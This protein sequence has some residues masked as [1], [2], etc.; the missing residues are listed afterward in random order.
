MTQVSLPL[1]K[2]AALQQ[3]HALQKEEI[4]ALRCKVEDNTGIMA[5]C[6]SK[7]ISME[8]MTRGLT[9]LTRGLEVIEND[10][11]MESSNR[12]EEIEKLSS[13][14]HETLIKAA[15]KLREE[16]TALS[17]EIKGS[18]LSRNNSGAQIV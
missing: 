11:R 3:E 10:V 4:A 12:H 8:H 14:I 18:R 15:A 9:S 6:T 13:K 7:M 17:S 5:Q 2:I 1:Q 16:F